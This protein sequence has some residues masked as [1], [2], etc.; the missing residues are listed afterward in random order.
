ML[1]KLMFA[2]RNAGANSFDKVGFA[3]K[4]H[5]AARDQIGRAS[6]IAN[7]TIPA[8]TIKPTN[9]MLPPNLEKQFNRLNSKQSVK[10][11]TP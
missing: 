10:K 1:T 9:P 6:P 4:A 11:N 7:N 8:M 3:P 2:G 5:F